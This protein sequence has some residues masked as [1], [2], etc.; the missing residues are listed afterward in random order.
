MGSS[1]VFNLSLG[2]IWC[3]D[4]RVFL[5]AVIANGLKLIEYMDRQSRRYIFWGIVLAIFIGA[6]GSCW[7]VFHLVHIHGGINLDAWRFKLGPA[8]I[9]DMTVRTLKPTEI[10]W[11]GWSFFLGGGIVMLA[12]T[13]ARQRL[14]WWPV[15]PIGFPVGSNMLMTHI[16]FSV[17][18]A[19][20]VK[21]SVLRFGGAA[22]YRSSQTFFL[23]LIMG[24]VLC[25]GIWI[26]I[27]Y[28]TGKVGN[29]LFGLG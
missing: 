2:Y 19:W 3:A 14:L 1:G 20:A 18:I 5:M 16:W 7:M 27:D 8:T 23:G 10:Y 29:S 28:F 4:I 6:V 26:I 24:E 12:L 9:Y 15:H 13:W 21:K 22:L 17:F 25:N 11:P